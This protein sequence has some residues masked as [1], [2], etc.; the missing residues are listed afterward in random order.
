MRLGTLVQVVFDGADVA[1][2]FG[3]PPAA[4]RLMRVT[5]SPEGV[6]ADAIIVELLD[7]LN[8]AQGVVVATNDRQLQEGVRRRGG[9]VMTV[10]QLMAVVGRTGNSSGSS[11]LRWPRSRQRKGQG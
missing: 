2:R 6:D 11:G 1:G 10:A 8:S 9:N 3:P 7:Q 4:R 5:F